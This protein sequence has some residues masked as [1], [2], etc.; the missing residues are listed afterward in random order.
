M[1]LS[2]LASSKRRDLSDLERR[3]LALQAELDAGKSQLDRN[4]LGQ[5]ATPPMLAGEIVRAARRLLGDVPVRF[6][7]PAFG[8]GA[9]YHALLNTF[10]R[11][12]IELASGY[13]IDPY[14][15]APT[16]QLWRQTGLVIHLADFT[17]AKPP[18]TEEERF[19]L[20]VCNPPYVRHHHLSGEDKERLREACQR[21]CRLRTNGLSGL[22]CYFLVLCHG[23][24][25]ADG[26]GVWLVPSEFMDVKYG[27][28]VKRYLTEKVTLIR[29]HRFDPGEVQF[30]DALVSSAVVFFQK[31]PPENIAHKVAFTF[32]GTLENP[33]AEREV[34]LTVLRGER[35]W[36][37]FPLSDERTC[38]G[39]AYIL[40]DFFSIK[41]GIATGDNSYF[42]MTAERAR[43][44]ALPRMFL[45]PIL[46]SPR[47][48]QD[49]EILSDKD[50][51]PLVE[52]RLFLL[53]CRLPEGHVHAK[54][55][56]L[57]RYFEEGK[58]HGVNNRYLC[59]HRSPWYGQEHRPPAPFLCTY[60][61]RSD[62][63]NLSP[64]RFI[65]N[66]SVAV[67]A[68]VYLLMYP[69]GVLVSALQSQPEL[70]D[71]IWTVLKGLKRPA[72]LAEGRVYGGGLHKLEPKELGNVP[73]DQIAALL[74]LPRK[75]ARRQLDLF[76]PS[77]VGGRP[78]STWNL[79]R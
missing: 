33:R 15:G 56:S 68:N 76:H 74:G 27:L 35:K 55:P 21:A 28:W 40:A 69:K 13:E 72:L 8:T 9:F 49:G 32:G 61:G 54:Y 23:W 30:G 58:K 63:G 59:R 75:A 17:K 26:L 53:D 41:R 79:S 22:Y 10:P 52:P 16:R 70:C 73:A 39:S 78:T 34:P 31:R 20:I 4:R 3:R 44:L 66:R 2:N 48:V 71:R 43:E 25:A 77:H 38:D 1:T 42:I 65:L 36:T 51:N 11:D 57:W 7:D 29:I 64:F 12:R 37:R 14:Y 45:R 46:P 62:N 6:L 50:G 5:F 67:A 47:Y 19:N 18:E 60:M 24:L